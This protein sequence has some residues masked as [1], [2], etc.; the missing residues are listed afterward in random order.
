[1]SNTNFCSLEERLSKHPELHQKIEQLLS[2]VESTDDDLARA[3][4][5]E[6]QVIKTLRE[7]GHD[8]LSAWATRRISQTSAQ[9]N[10]DLTLR[11]CGQKN[12][13]GAVPTASSR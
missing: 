7:M 1:M 3:D 13:T 2:V 5:A 12:S 6:R 11:P 8:A 9:S 4:E 10:D